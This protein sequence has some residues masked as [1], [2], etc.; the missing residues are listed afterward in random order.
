MPNS[1]GGLAKY[2]YTYNAIGL[3]KTWINYG[4]LLL[5][6]ST[7]DF[8]ES[9]RY[10]YTYN[11]KNQLVNFSMYSDGSKIENSD[12]YY[13]RFGNDSLH[14]FTG[15]MDPQKVTFENSYNG[16]KL[17]STLITHGFVRATTG[18]EPDYR[19]EYTYDSNGNRSSSIDYYWNPTTGAQS[20]L[21][22][23]VFYYDPNYL[24][25]DVLNVPELYSNTTLG[26]KLIRTTSFASRTGGSVASVDYYYYSSVEINTAVHTPST[27]KVSFYPNPAKDF[28]QISGIDNI[29]TVLITD[30]NGK[31][32]QNTNRLSAN[33]KIYIGNFP[34]GMYIVKVI[35]DKKAFQ[36]K[37]VKQ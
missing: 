15:S 35:S 2:G 12:R 36:Q 1:W 4:L 26:N 11:A 5:S 34:K 6:D 14:V 30:L 20:S 9:S 28:L 13:D 10:E 18:W 3:R 22:R 29:K 16:D 23:A 37:I 17:T 8:F 33:D 19:M 31:L 27:D 7:F 21:N 25:T 24:A 32:I